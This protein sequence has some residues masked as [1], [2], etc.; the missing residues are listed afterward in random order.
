MAKQQATSLDQM[1]ARGFQALGAVAEAAGKALEKIGQAQRVLFIRKEL[2]AAMAQNEVTA[3][4]KQLK[5][6]EALLG[7]RINDAAHRTV[8]EVC[9]PV[10]AT[11]SVERLGAGKPALLRR[12][13]YAAKLL[14]RK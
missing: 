3:D 6:M 2:Q 9:G 10:K 7:T 8:M 4:K 11:A 1:N 12:K 14:K 13:D 5:R